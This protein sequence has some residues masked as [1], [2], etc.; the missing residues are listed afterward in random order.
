MFTRSEKD[1]SERAS[2]GDEA[3]AA[4]KMSL[5]L[6][7]KPSK[8]SSLVDMRLKAEPRAQRSMSLVAQSYMYTAKE[9]LACAEPRR[10]FALVSKYV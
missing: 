2:T 3:A 10:D 5:G 1:E 4:D 6:P 9:Q 8:R 7:R